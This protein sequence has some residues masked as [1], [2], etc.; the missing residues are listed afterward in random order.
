MPCYGP[1]CTQYHSRMGTGEFGPRHVLQHNQFK[2]WPATRSMCNFET[3]AWKAS[4]KLGMSSS[5]SGVSTGCC[6]MEC[7]WDQARNREISL[8]KRLHGQCSLIDQNDYLLIMV[9]SSGDYVSSQLA[10]TR[11]LIDWLIDWLSEQGLTSPPTHY[12]LSGRQFYRS[13]DPTSSIKVLKEKT[14]QKKRK[15][16]KANNTKCSNTIKRHIQKTQQVP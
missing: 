2:Y 5:C 7:A 9:I 11:D 4:F 6:F 15:P 1:C 8:F 12:K 13:K 14:P 3:A 16:R 10:D